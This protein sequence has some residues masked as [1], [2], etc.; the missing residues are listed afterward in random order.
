[1]YDFARLLLEED[2]L[3]PANIPVIAERLPPQAI[4]TNSLI[5]IYLD[6]FCTL[7]EYL[8]QHASFAVILSKPAK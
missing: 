7:I 6:G 8:P 4:K 5:I 2:S 1:M 3:V